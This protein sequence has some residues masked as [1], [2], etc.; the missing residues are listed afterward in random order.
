MAMYLAGTGGSRIDIAQY[1]NGRTFDVPSS[2]GAMTITAW[3]KATTLGENQRIFCKASGTIP[4]P[5][6]GGACG[7]FIRVGDVSGTKR[8]GIG[9]RTGTTTT[10]LSD[11]TTAIVTG[12]VYFVALWY[13]G[14]NMKIYINASEKAS[15]AKTGNVEV[16]SAKPVYIG[17]NPNV[18][19]QFN[20]VID[21][22]RVYTR[23]LRVNELISIYY[24]NSRDY[25]VQDLY[26]QWRL[27]E[28]H[29][30]SRYTDALAFRDYSNTKIHGEE[31]AGKCLV[32]TA[33]NTQYVNLASVNSDFQL[34]APFT[35]EAWI[36]PSSASGV[37]R[38]FGTKNGANNGV[39]FGRNSL[40]MR[41]TLHGVRDY[42]TASDRLTA[43]VWQHVAVVFQTGGLLGR[44]ALFYVNGS[45]VET[46]TAD[47]IGDPG[48]TLSGAQIGADGA[49]GEPWDGNIDH[50]KVYKGEA[51]SAAN[52]SLYKD[53]LP[54]SS[55]NLK[56][57]MRFPEGT[58][59]T[60]ADSSG[61]SHNGTLT[62]TTGTPTWDDSG[63]MSTMPIYNDPI[64]PFA[65]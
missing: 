21:D 30:S 43:N 48:T 7:Y 9:L 61:N 20:G 22:V 16:N 36:Y 3:F 34:V 49:N 58:G 59:T 4:D 6:T 31:D 2:T 13:D 56:L 47:F 40:K 38:I 52:I 65:T 64:T 39:S 25:I 24:G 63:A 17:D 23:A 10:F 26:A 57:Y 15:T 41:L 46:I 44:S 55:S 27:N 53:E 29:V 32:F 51:R 35:I 11:T 19:V 12:T 18:R 54:P 8:V 28:R 14:S 1:Y 33:S 5:D 45:L 37:K 42:D 60:T 50:V 62:G